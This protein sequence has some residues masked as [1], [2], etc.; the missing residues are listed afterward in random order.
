MSAFRRSGD[1]NFVKST[2][3]LRDPVEEGHVTG[4]V[5]LADHPARH[6]PAGDRHRAIGLLGGIRLQLKRDELFWQRLRQFHKRD[7]VFLRVLVVALM[8]DETFDLPRLRAGREPDHRG[9]PDV[10]RNR[11]IRRIVA[12]P[13]AEAVGGRKHPSGRDERSAAR[14]DVPPIG[15]AVERGLPRPFAPWRRLASDHPRVFDHARGLQL[16]ERV[17]DRVGFRRCAR[18]ETAAATQNAPMFRCFIEPSFK[19]VDA[20]W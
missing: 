6:A 5:F 12:A 4:F 3:L 16:P 14:E 1:S 15:H 17:L 19:A 9:L 13:F 10:R 18:R 2:C 20:R 7:I 11:P 8:H